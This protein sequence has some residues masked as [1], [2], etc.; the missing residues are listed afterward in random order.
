MARVIW[1][2]EVL[3]NLDAVGDYMLDLAPS[4]PEA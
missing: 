1:T 3:R 4:F 2:P